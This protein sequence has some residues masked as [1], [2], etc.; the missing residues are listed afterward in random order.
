[1]STHPDKNPDD[2]DATAQFQQVSE[3]YNVLSKHLDRNS[4]PT[5]DRHSR[6]AFG[7][8]EDDEDYEYSSDEYY[9][10]DYEDDEMDFYM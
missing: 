2:P 7:Y 9:D 3:A 10:E 5:L 6:G 8:D 4:R 1:M